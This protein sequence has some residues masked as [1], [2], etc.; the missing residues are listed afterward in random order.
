MVS[1]TDSAVTKLIEMKEE[2]PSKGAF[3]VS[4]RGFG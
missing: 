2:D 3:R 1:I 4:F